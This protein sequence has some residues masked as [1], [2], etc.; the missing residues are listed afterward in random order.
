MEKRQH[1]QW[2]LLEKMNSYMQKDETRS[3][4]HTIYKT[5][6]WTK[7]LNTR[8]ETIKLLEGNSIFFNISLNNI[9]RTCLLSQGGKKRKINKNKKPKWDSVQSL[10]H[11]WFFATPWTTALQAFLSITNSQSLLKLMSIHLVMPSNHLILWH[12][13][14]LPS[15]FPSIR[16]FSNESALRIRWPKHWSF[17]FNISTSNEYS[18]L[19]PL[20]WTGWISL[21]S[22][23]LSRIFSNTTFQ[24]HQFFSA[25]LSL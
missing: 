6:K 12:L 13:L 5:N 16:V 2:M 8:P 7:N 4:S 23:G 1:L 25:Q 14:L 10:S 20:E 17:S 15:F 24:K 18:G 22:K 19:F 9:F 21:Q 3:L 11:V